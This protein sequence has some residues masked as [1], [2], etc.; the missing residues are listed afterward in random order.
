MNEAHSGYLRCVR[1]REL[2]RALLP[3]AHAGGVRH[4]AMEALSTHVAERANASRKLEQPSPGGYLGQPEMRK[5]IDAAL[6]LGWTLHAYEADFTQSPARDGPE[7]N[8]AVNWREDQQARNLAAVV[9]AVPA[10]ERILGWCGMGH[11]NRQAL[12]ASVDGETVTWTPMGSLVAGYCG[13]EPFALDQVMTVAW[14]G[15]EREWL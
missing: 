13:V 11:L 15:E 1:T 8:A 12:T 9:S 7:D 6:G 10:S 2:G 4:L 14:D 3:V 5:L